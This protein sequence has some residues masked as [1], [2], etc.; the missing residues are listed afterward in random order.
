MDILDSFGAR[1]TRIKS[2][3]R[4]SLVRGPRAGFGHSFIHIPKVLS[5]S[6]LVDEARRRVTAQPLPPGL[7]LSANTLG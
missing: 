1:L 5:T 3:S 4:H 7:S 6:P 2:W